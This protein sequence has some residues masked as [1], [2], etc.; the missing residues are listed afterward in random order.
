M[1]VLLPCQPNNEASGVVVHKQ[2]EGMPM[3]QEK[4]WHERSFYHQVDLQKSV[5]A[6]HSMEINMIQGIRE[7]KV[8]TNFEVKKKK[9]HSNFDLDVCCSTRSGLVANR[10]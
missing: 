2:M 3:D 8:D 6:F 4:S 1:A 7:H 10:N 5:E 9:T